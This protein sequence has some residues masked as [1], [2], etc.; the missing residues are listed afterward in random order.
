VFLEAVE[1]G[2]G[3][4]IGGAATSALEVDGPLGDLSVEVRLL[5]QLFD[6][7]WDSVARL[8]WGLPDAGPRLVIGLGAGF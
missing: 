4:G 6:A 5:A 1:L 8:S 2:L 7:P 3:A